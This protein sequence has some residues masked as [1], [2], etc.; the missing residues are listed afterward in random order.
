[1]RSE[2]ISQIR[3]RIVLIDHNLRSDVVVISDESYQWNGFFGT[4][5]NHT[6]A[7]RTEQRAVSHSKGIHYVQI[8]S[9]RSSDWRI[10]IDRLILLSLSV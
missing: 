8:G 4:K 2:V 1:M 3:H 5:S 10:S 6:I 9:F 7:I